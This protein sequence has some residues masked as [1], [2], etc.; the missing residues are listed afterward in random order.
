M[1][2]SKRNGDA[3]VRAQRLVHAFAVEEP[4]IEDRDDAP[5]SAVGDRAVDVD[6]RFT[7]AIT[8]VDPSRPVARSLA[9]CV[10]LRACRCACSTPQQMREADR[11]TIEDIG[12]PSIVLMENAGRQ[13]VAAME[14]AFD[15][16]AI[17]RVGRAVRP[18]QQRRRRLRR[19]ARR[20]SQRGIDAAVFLLG[21]VADVQRRRAHQP[22]GPRPH[23]HRRRRDHRRAG[24]GAALHRDLECDLIVDAIVGTG[25]TRPLAG[26]LE[27][28]VADV[29]ALGVPVVAIDLP[30]GLSADTPRS[31]GAAI[32]ASMTVTLARRSCRWCCRRPSARR[33]P[34]DRRHRHSAAA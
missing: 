21:R 4:V 34:R 9:R 6:R 17:E 2:R 15:D 7:A 27:T 24:V 18:R 19:R 3:V 33:R 29:N 23:R 32:E 11:R 30:S 25:F 28:V 31:T 5:A 16:L 10:R 26:L 8:R 20:C 14:A 1:C 12:I 22:R 13:V